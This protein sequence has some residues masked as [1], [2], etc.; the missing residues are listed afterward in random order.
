MTGYKRSTRNA[1]LQRL[2]SMDLIELGPPITATTAGMKAL[3]AKF[4]P[5]PTGRALREYWLQKL[6]EGESKILATLLA[7]YPKAVSRDAVGDNL[8]YA[9][10]S[11]NAY[12][13]RLMSRQLLVKDGK[14]IRASPTLF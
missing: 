13:Q 10:S 9:R 12:I 6:P 2:S 7:A 4:E 11:R 14:Q 1:Y 8:P 5:L 3:G